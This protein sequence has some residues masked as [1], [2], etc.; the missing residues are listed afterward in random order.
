MKDR[1]P[2]RRIRRL[3]LLAATV[4]VVAAGQAVA[5]E[6]LSDAIAEQGQQALRSMA[7]ELRDSAQWQDAG[8]RNLRELLQAPQRPDAKHQFADQG[9]RG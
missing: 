4:A 9:E 7:G 3:T 6:A 1:T 8:L 2:S 5:G